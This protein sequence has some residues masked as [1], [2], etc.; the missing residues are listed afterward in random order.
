MSLNSK[1]NSKYFCNFIK[2]KCLLKKYYVFMPN[3]KKII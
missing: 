1:E 2:K 3:K